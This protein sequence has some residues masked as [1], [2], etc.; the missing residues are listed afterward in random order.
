MIT[1]QRGETW[2]LDFDVV[3]DK[4]DPLMLFNQ[5]K[6]PYLAITL[7]DT[8]YKQDGD[9]RRTYWLDLADTYEEQADGSFVQKPIKK[10]IST[11]ALYLEKFDE[12]PIEVLI[13]INNL[14]GGTKMVTDD[15]TSEFYY[16]NY[17]FYTDPLSDGNRVY[18]Y[19]NGTEW[20]DYNFRI[21]KQFKTDDLVS[22]GYLFDMKIV[23]GES[24]REHIADMVEPLDTRM[25][26]LLDSGAP[27][28]PD[29]DVKLLILQPTELH[30]STNLQGGI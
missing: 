26:E 4:G 22:Q 8:T 27:L 14:Y 20:V 30:I 23:A 29:Y 11:E 24:V 7:T 16:T 18:K 9:F 19:H 12:A 3:N 21:I 6:N 25:Q 13:D 5:W 1:I 28:M 15:S 10:F 17:L 2:S